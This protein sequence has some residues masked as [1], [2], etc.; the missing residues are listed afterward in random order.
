MPRRA[1]F[2]GIGVLSPLGL[3]LNTYWNGLGEGRSGVR[4]ITL[5]DASTFAVNIAGELPA[6]DAKNFFEKKDRKSLKMMARPIQIGV[7]CANMCMTDAGMERGKIDPTRFGI[8]FGSSMIPTD[9][10]D[11]VAAAHTSYDFQAAEVNLKKWGTDSIPTMSPLWMLKFLPNMVACHVSILHDAQGPN[12]SITETDAAGLLAIGEAFRILRRDQADFFLCGGADSKLNV[13]SLSRHI[14]FSKL[15]KRNHDPAGASRPFDKDRDGL[16]MSEGAGVLAM[17]ELEHA[18]KRGANIYGELCG[19]GSAFDREL[20]GTGVARA[21][22]I[23]IKQA[24]IG[25]NDIDHVN[26]HGEATREADK[27]EARG[28]HT[29][30]GPNV[31]VF[32]AKSFMGNLGSAGGPVEL[33]ASLLAL[34]N[35]TLPKTLNYTQPDS[36]CP[37]HVM[38]EPRKVTKNYALKLSLTELGQVGAAVVRKWEG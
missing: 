10:D 38:T 2:T 33:A 14:L 27:W 21:I 26:A 32:A 23:A 24:G 4:N 7:G 9:I 16:V 3:D 25:P 31:P 20:D 8:E 30:F 22:N 12:N 13:L 17:E 18:K 19:F 36:E 5:F 1:V 11:L 35:G 37:V 34:K 15:S 28:I 29:V 6:F